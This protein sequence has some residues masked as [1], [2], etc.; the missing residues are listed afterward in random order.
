[1]IIKKL[2]KKYEELQMQVGS[3]I[4]EEFIIQNKF[5]D[6]DKIKNCPFCNRQDITIKRDYDTLLEK[7]TEHQFYYIKCNNC[8][9]KTGSFQEEKVDLLIEKWNEMKR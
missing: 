2:R 7:E 6:I 4:L 5:S 1:M 8:D 3:E 9:M